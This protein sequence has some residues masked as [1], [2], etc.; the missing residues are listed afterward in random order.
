MKKSMLVVVALIAMFVGSLHA[1]VKVE[2]MTWADYLAKFDDSLALTG[3]GNFYIGRSYLTLKGDI[4]EKVAAR[5]TLDIAKGGDHLFKYAYVDWKIAKPLALTFGLQKVHFGYMPS[6]KYVIPVKAIADASKA[7][8]SADLG[9]GVGGKV[10]ILKYNVQ[11]LNGEGYKNWGKGDSDEFYAVLANVIVTPMKSK[12]SQLDIG[13]SFRND[14]HGWESPG[15]V[16]D[17][18]QALDVFAMFKLNPISVMVEFVAKIDGTNMDNYLNVNLGFSPSKQ[19]TL[20]TILQMDM[21][22]TNMPSDI[23]LGANISPVKGFA[24]KPMIGA[25]VEIGENPTFMFQT[26]FEYKIGFKVGEKP[27]SKKVE[28]PKE[29]APIIIEPKTE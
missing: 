20:M 29:E 16:A 22:S 25:S 23:Y 27:K 4:S 3:N 6:W 14:Q 8:A 21:S 15:V 13:V 5:L 10:S 2:S 19:F 12:T 7:S 28:T 26:Q 9:I 18:T 24:I 1:V 17:F 11:L